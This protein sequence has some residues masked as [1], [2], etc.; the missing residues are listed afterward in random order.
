MRTLRYW[1]KFELPGTCATMELVPQQIISEPL[2][3]FD[4]VVEAI[5][6]NGFS[7]VIT[8]NNVKVLEA[9]TQGDGAFPD[10]VRARIDEIET[11]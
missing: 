10:R 9:S 8:E 5:K 7:Y 6:A 3:H 2:M 1:K 11:V 4:A